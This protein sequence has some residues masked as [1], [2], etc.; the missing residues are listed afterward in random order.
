MRDDRP[1]RRRFMPLRILWGLIKFSAFLLIVLVIAY[2][3]SEYV[4]Q[5]TTVH[6][7]SME[8]TLSE[9]DNVLMDKIS[10]KL[11][12]PKRYDII[13]FKS[14]KSDEC[15]IK[16]VI[17]LPGEKIHIIDGHIFINNSEID[18]YPDLPAIEGSGRAYDPIELGD[19]EFFVIG[20]NREESVDSRSV[21]VGNVKR[22]NILGKAWLRIY[23]FDRFGVVK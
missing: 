16:R 11:H 7:V 22:S 17:G 5:R 21:V 15:L 9:G 19:D 20:D 18:D 10:Y 4:I 3:L 1:K 23:P 8:I 14:E 12:D 6:N 13:C 2:L